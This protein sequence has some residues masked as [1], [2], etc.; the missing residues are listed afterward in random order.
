[1]AAQQVGYPAVMRL[2][3]TLL[4]ANTSRHYRSST[5]QVP[6]LSTTNLNVENEARSYS[7][8][9]E[10]EFSKRNMSIYRKKS[11]AK[12]GRIFLG[13]TMMVIPGMMTNYGGLET[14][15]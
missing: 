14:I 8:I 3:E 10:T 13:K 12:K 9:I 4:G 5:Q 15:N 2:T 6:P 11:R 1:M 7:K